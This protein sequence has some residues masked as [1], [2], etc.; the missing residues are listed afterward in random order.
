MNNYLVQQIKSEVA[1]SGFSMVTFAAMEFANEASFADAD[2]L[3][4]AL[5]AFIAAKD[6]LDGYTLDHAR[7]T[8]MFDG[9]IVDPEP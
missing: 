6:W 8:A 9:P 7:K 2:A 1:A 5:D 3:I 4:T